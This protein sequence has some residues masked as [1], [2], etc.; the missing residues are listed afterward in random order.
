VCAYA[1]GISI[2]THRGWACLGTLAY[3]GHA[4]V[5]SPI[6]RTGYLGRRHKS[7]SRAV[8]LE[9]IRRVMGLLTS[10]VFSEPL[11]L[12]AVSLPLVLPR[13]LGDGGLGGL[14]QHLDA[15]LEGLSLVAAALWLLIRIVR[16]HRIGGLRGRYADAG[17]GLKVSGPFKVA[18]KPLPFDPLSTAHIELS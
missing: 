13:Q 2:Y 7:T 17:G 5:A 3:R 1:C 18:H 6:S 8:E 16:Y 15:T 11:V 9:D 10:G 14:E 4:R 12:L